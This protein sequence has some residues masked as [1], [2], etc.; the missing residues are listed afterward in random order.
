MSKK[1]KIGIFIYPNMTMLD[2][3]GPLQFLSFVDS[4]ET[5]TFAKSKELIPCDAGVL[6]APNYGFDDCPEIDV[7]IV[8]GGGNPFPQ[9][10]DKEVVEFLRA[11]GS[12]SKYVTSVCTGSLILAETGLL[13]NYKT[14]IHWAYSDFM[15]NYPEVHVVSDRVVIDRNR[16]SGGGVT[17][18]I[19][20]AL[21]LISEI[22]GEREAKKIQLLLE[23]NPQPPFNA[24]S[25][26]TA[27]TSLVAEVQTMVNTVCL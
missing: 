1:L 10:H 7:L 9:V 6:L 22:A 19:D 26:Q 13:D 5:F 20:F 4:F 12:I 8:S 27:D 17:S 25:P 23:Y 3:Y 24:G 2:A 15:N 11:K 21:T 18:G 16:I 14:A